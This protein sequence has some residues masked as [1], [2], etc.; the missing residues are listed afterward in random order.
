MLVQKIETQGAKNMHDQS[1][2]I[3]P[4]ILNN[5]HVLQTENVKPSAETERAF[6]D[7]LEPVLR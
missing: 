3:D 2:D 1:H 6:R 7:V 5:V 4:S